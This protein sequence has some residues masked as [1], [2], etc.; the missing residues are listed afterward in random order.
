MMVSNAAEAENEVLD[1]V[2]E[3]GRV[4][5]RASRAESHSNPA[6]AH[7]AVHVVVRNAAG[8]IFL[9][10]RSRSKRIQP[11]KWDTSVGGHVDPGESYEAAAVR[12]LSEELGISMATGL[13]HLYDYIWRSPVETEHVRTF[14]LTHEGPFRLHPD[15]I[16]EG[17]FWSLEETGRSLGT[18]VFTPNLEEELRR[19]GEMA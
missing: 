7:R 9:Q 1:I 5:G 3:Q 19:L 13:R 10:K 4:I 15:E 14:L 2:D 16:E 6:L 11:G 12:E 8:D 18:G 17:R